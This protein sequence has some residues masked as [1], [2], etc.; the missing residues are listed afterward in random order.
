MPLCVFHKAKDAMV[1]ETVQME[2]MSQ[3]VAVSHNRLH[4]NQVVHKSRESIFLGIDSIK[5]GNLEKMENNQWDS[6][7]QRFFSSGKSTRLPVS[8]YK[9][10]N[11]INNKNPGL[12]ICW[13]RVQVPL[14]PP[15]GFDLWKP[16]LN[17]WAVLVQPT[18]LRPASCQ[19]I[20]CALLLLYSKS[21][22]GHFCQLK[23]TYVLNEVYY[24][25]YFA[26]FIAVCGY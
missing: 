16:W 25:I 10:I 12:E 20:F 22:S 19:F 5:G 11:I 3:W 1:R 17:S 7:C 24:F 9:K 23:S 8:K 13:P 4:F 21:T 14:W 2:R 15:T 18:S 6:F 26:T